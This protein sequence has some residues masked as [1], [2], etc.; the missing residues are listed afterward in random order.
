MTCA[1]PMEQMQ[2]QVA[3]AFYVTAMDIHPMEMLH[4]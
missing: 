4:S 2:I 3:T 1:L